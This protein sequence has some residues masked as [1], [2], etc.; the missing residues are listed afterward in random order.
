MSAGRKSIPYDDGVNPVV[1]VSVDT[2]KSFS[3]V[4]G[5]LGLQ[6]QLTDDIN[7][8]GS[9]NRGYKSGGFFGGQTTSLL[10]LAAY[11]DEVVDA[12]EVG[13]KSQWPRPADGE[14]CSVLLRLPGPAGLYACC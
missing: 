6:Y 12:Y 4:S 13:L 1:P 2:S 10:S 3:S 14:L 7:L 11:N 5:K 9:Y 8:Y